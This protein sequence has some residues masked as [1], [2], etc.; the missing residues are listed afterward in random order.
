M[1]VL[2]EI[3]IIEAKLVEKVEKIETVETIRYE[4][5]PQITQDNFDILAKKYRPLMWKYIRLVYQ[6]HS[7]VVEICDLEQE[8]LIA[9]FNSIKNFDPERKVYFQVYLAKAVL[10]KLLCYCRNTLP[11][12]YKKDPENPGKFLRQKVFVDTLDDPN[13]PKF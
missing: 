10:N 5:D 11:H 2:Q 4:P 7:R 6:M 3:T 8:A 12:Y 9:L 13:N 1:E